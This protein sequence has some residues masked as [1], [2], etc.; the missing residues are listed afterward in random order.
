MIY[1]LALFALPYL[2]K[3]G[4]GV[5]PHFISN[6]SSSSMVGFGPADAL[7]IA[8]KQAQGGGGA[9]PS[10]VAMAA[11]GPAALLTTPQGKAAVAKGLVM[12]KKAAAG[13]RK[14]QK[15]IKDT[16]RRAAQGDPQAK[17]DLAALRA[18]Q[19]VQDHV[20]EEDDDDSD[21]YGDEE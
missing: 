1:L 17:K 4:M 15:Q 11:L 19:M 8:K 20:D 7:K 5:N 12:A 16:Q 21:D 9:G 2:L 14:S 13:D 10:P 18:A 3:K 6:K